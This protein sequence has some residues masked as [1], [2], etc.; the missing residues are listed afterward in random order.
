MLNTNVIFQKYATEQIT[1]EVA[2]EIEKNLKTF[3]II[4]LSWQD[5]SEGGE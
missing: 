2:N 5:E 1:I 4:L 3:F